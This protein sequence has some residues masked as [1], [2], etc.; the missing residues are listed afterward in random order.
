MYCPKCKEVM[1]VIE[2]KQI[3]T[4]YC[5]QC[6]GIWLDHGELE[7]ILEDNEGKNASVFSSFTPDHKSAETAY[8]CP[9]CKKKMEK[10]RCGRE[11]ELL[12]DSCY[13]DHGLWF[14]DGELHELIST[15]TDSD[16]PV[17]GLLHEMFRFKLN[18]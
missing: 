17:V 1:I 12:I 9:I 15:Y 16:D 10:V 18:N 5:T 8:P 7:L 11:K 4:D 3:E 2:L 6:S 14:D 13:N